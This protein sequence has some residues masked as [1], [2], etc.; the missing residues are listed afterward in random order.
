MKLLTSKNIFIFAIN[1][2]GS[3]L[4]GNTVANVDVK[5]SI[6]ACDLTSSKVV[7]DTSKMKNAKINKN[8]DRK[9]TG[10]VFPLLSSSTSDKLILGSVMKLVESGEKCVDFNLR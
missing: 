2:V 7:I 6:T 4:I 3:E 5:L 1:S 9:N 10:V 8:K